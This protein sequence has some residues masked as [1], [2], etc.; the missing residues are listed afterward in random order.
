[1]EASGQGHGAAV[2][3]GYGVVLAGFAALIVLPV[4]TRPTGDWEQVYLA[5]A[6][7]L[8]TGGDVWAGG[9]SY[10]YPPFGAL[11]AVPFT[12]LSRSL[13]LVAWAVMNL[14]ALAVVLAG[15][16][17]LAGGRG[18]PASRAD[19]LAFWLGGACAA[20]FLLDAAAN[21]QTDLLIAAGVVAGCG[22]LVRGRPLAAGGLLGAAAA[23]KCTPLL[24][25]PYLVW[26]RRVLA[27]ATV[28]TVTLT[29]NLLPDLIYPPADGH[30]RLWLWKDRFLSPMTRADYDP[31]MWAS[32]VGFNHSLAGV[33]LRLFAYDRVGGGGPAAAV[34]RSDRP[35]AAD[36][37]RLNLTLAALLGLVALVALARR[38]DEV[39]P[40]PVFAA[41]VGIVVTLML[42]LSPMSSKPHFGLLLVPQLAVVRVGLA[43]RDRCLLGIGG[44]AAVAG[45]AA[46]KDVV[47]RAAYEVLMWNG[48][49]CGTTLLL[50]VGCCLVCRRYGAMGI[51]PIGKATS[52]ITLAARRQA[53]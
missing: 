47:G 11:A 51:N 30:S 39:M 19:H 41:E 7:Q 6:R 12:G 13:G 22:C 40:G 23:F 37:K 9:T 42:L 26:K 1:M 35:S 2:A 49:V 3:A 48:L 38:R 28:P 31:G 34:V 43:H 4:L 15:A 5:A 16:W 20:G 21:W 45:L 32:A 50:F 14:V 44:L 36:L 29:L 17:R 24:F 52:D 53:A 33:T 27:A 8:R 46:G 10:V 25:A 18:L